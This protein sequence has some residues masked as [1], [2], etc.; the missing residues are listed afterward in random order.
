MCHWEGGGECHDRVLHLQFFT[1]ILCMYKAGELSVGVC[2]CIYIY[3]LFSD[4]NTRSISIFLPPILATVA[5]ITTPDKSLAVSI[6]QAGSVNRGYSNY[7][8]GYR[9]YTYFT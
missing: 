8:I 5:A 7:I 2:V 6:Q 4:Q 1:L 3:L 9:S